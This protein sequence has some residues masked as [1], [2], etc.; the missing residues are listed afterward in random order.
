MVK[1]NMIV[2][3]IYFNLQALQMFHISIT[4]SIQR[5]Q[6]ANEDDYNSNLQMRM[7]FFGTSWPLQ[8]KSSH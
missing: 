7:I 6:P 2:V 8:A 3:S 1:Q 5:F 4:V